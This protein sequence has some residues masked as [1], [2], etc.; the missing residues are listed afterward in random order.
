MVAKRFKRPVE[1]ASTKLSQEE[2]HLLV[3]KLVLSIPGSRPHNNRGL[4]SELLYAANWFVDPEMINDL[5]KGEAF[6]IW[7]AQ[8]NFVG[9]SKELFELTSWPMMDLLEIP[10]V[11]LFKR[12]NKYT[13]NVVKA[14][15]KAFETRAPVY[16]VCEPHDVTESKENPVTVEIS[17]RCIV[18]AFDEKEQI[19]GFIAF[20]TIRARPH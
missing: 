5:K 10:W 11:N 19:V 6:E 1:K 7:D 13:E 9:A 12:D 17:V 3:R 14:V 20:T 4:L 8:L 15:H 18:P 2:R 16:D